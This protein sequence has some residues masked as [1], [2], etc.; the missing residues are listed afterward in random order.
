[1]NRIASTPCSWGVLDFNLKENIPAYKQVLVEMKD[2]GYSGTELGQWGFLPTMAFDLREALK[3][4]KLTLVGA[5]VPVALQ[6]PDRHH[7]G[8]E[9]ALETAALMY[10]AGY[11]EALL[12]LSDEF[13]SDDERTSH[14]GRITSEMGLS[15]EDWSNFISAAEMIAKEVRK[16]F[17]LRTAFHPHCGGYV[18]TPGEVETFMQGSDPSLLGLCLDTAHCTFGG[19]DPAEAVEKYKDRLWH[20]H[21]KDL[22][23]R[24]DEEAARNSYN[25]FKSLEEGLFCELGKGSVDFKSIY[26]TLIKNH[27][28]GWIVLEQELLPGMVLPKSLA[29][30]NTDFIA[31][32]S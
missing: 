32:L 27:Y 15:E 9:K 14:A 2:A 28:N 30:K 31:N 22:N 17:A 25:Y 1:M 20:V 3:E 11:E 8:L 21:F 18:E 26:K 24:I 6:D 7:Q 5:F 29:Q 16:Q 13:G 12:I 19:G 10:H 4:S 23:P